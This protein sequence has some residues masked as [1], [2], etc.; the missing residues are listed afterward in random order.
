MKQSIS[1]SRSVPLPRPLLSMGWGALRL[2]R[3]G[4]PPAFGYRTRL[5][6][7]RRSWSPRCSSQHWRHGGIVS[8]DPCPHAFGRFHIKACL[9]SHQ[10]KGLRHPKVGGFLQLALETS[11]SL[12][13]QARQHLLGLGKLVDA[14]KKT[15]ER[16]HFLDNLCPV[17]SLGDDFAWEETKDHC[18]EI[19]G[20]HRR[21]RHPKR[22]DRI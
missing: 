9:L 15:P 20:G 8:V 10:D 5:L 22:A 3:R 4:V 21:W 17:A 19:T 13:C 1:S 6:F 16:A 12:Q 11:R 14:L 18:L 2:A 7:C